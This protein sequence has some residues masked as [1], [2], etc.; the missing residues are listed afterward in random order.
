M[1]ELGGL[2][3]AMHLDGM[4][5][6]RLGYSRD[7]IL[8]PAVVVWGHGWAYSVLRTGW[9][10]GMYDLG[11]LQYATDAPG[12]YAMH[13]V[14]LQQGCDPPVVAVWGHG[15]VYSVLRTGWVPGMNGLGGLQYA[16]DAPGWY[17]MHKVELQ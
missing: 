1:Y 7:V 14:E 17:A 5:C 16:T 2:R 13:Q 11:G 12:W 9:V 10:P 6:T 15:W 4:L 8:T 3:Y